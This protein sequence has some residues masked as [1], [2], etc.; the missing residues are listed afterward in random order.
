MKKT[1]ISHERLRRIIDSI[2]CRHIFL[3]M[4]VCFGGTFDPFI[5]DAPSPPG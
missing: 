4:D 3:V 5:A 1:Y 2:P